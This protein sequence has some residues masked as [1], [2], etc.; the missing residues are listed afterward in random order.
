MLFGFVMA[1]TLFATVPLHAAKPVAVKKAAPQNV[2]LNTMQ[3]ELTR[4]MTSLGHAA[5]Q[6]DAK[7]DGTQPLPPY[8]ISYDVAD[9]YSTRITAQYGALMSSTE[10]HVRLGDIQVRVGSPALDNTHGTHRTSAL[11]TISLPL[12]DDGDALARSLWFAT[13]RGYGNALQSYLPSRR[14]LYQSVALHAQATSSPVPA[15]SA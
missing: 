11:S 2:L 9:D 8:F 13:N 12:E 7:G 4:A 14:A 10:D 6:A 5:P 3:T 15:P 1:S